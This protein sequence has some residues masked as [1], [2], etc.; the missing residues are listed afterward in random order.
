MLMPLRWGMGGVRG[1][2]TFWERWVV[3][4]RDGMGDGV[5]EG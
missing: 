3:V 1:W 5:G 2:G 4:K